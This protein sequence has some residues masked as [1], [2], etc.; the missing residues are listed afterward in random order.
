MDN[1]LANADDN[2][3]EIS[4]REIHERAITNFASI[5]LRTILFAYK[6]M[7]KSTYLA[8]DPSL[9]EQDLTIL[10]LFGLRDFIRTEVP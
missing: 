5:A 6:D 1:L 3:L 8:M 7:P 2:N 9:L 4:Y 10:S